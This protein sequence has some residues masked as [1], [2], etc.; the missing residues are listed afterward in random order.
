VPPCTWF[1]LSAPKGLPDGI[2]QRLNQEVVTIMKIP[3]VQKKLAQDA[4]DPKPMTP[5]Q[6]VAFMAAETARWKPIAQAAGMKQ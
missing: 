4:F 6:V 1:A 3:D 5:E 2:A